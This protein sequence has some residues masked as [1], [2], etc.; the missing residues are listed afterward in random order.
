M[1]V[2]TGVFRAT[3]LGELF[4]TRMIALFAQLKTTA[5]F[6]LHEVMEQSPV[7]I[8]FVHYEYGDDTVSCR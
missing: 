8:A 4:G 5:E 1:V 7:L 3:A 2:I 6:I